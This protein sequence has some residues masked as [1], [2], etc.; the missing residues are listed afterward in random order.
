MRA[1]LLHTSLP[2]GLDGGT[3]FCVAACTGGM[4]AV[5]REALAAL[6]GLPE[7]WPGCSDWERTLRATRQVAWGGATHWVAT[8][9]RPCGVDHTGR[10]N[11]IAHHRVLDPAELE[12]CDPVA[13][14]ADHERWQAGWKGEPR[15]LEMPSAI[16]HL[17]GRRGPADRWALALGD[18]GSAAEALERAWQSGVGAWVVVPAGSDRLA[19]LAEMVSLLPMS[20]R[21]ARGWATRPLRPGSTAPVIAVVDEREPELLGAASGAAWVIRMDAARPAQASAAM[22]ELARRGPAPVEQASQPRD[23]AA[24]A[25]LAWRPP[26]RLAAGGAPALKP[27]D[28]VPDRSR[29][30]EPESTPIRVELETTRGWGAGL[31]LAMVAC[32]AVIGAVAWWLWG[33]GS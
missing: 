33:T 6:S 26:E 15:E 20:K 18:A 9:T 8:V 2:R 3:G 27:T 10:G 14:L 31:W 7:G 12:R 16:E 28:T 5:T 23:A 21:W 4:P 25:P 29:H 1:E 19:M 17:V 11:R 30:A 13:L 32:V 24:E 22:L